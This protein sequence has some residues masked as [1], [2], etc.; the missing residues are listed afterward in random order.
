MR[1]GL[2]IAEIVIA[3]AILAVVSGVALVTLNPF[4]QVA[5]ARNTQ[6][7]MHLTALMSA[8]KQNI[9]ETGDSSFTCAVGPI[10][11][12]PTLMQSS[13][14]YD[15]AECIVPTFIGSMPFDPQYPGARYVSDN[16][17]ST[18]Y[19]ISRSA[20]TGQVTLDAPQAELGTTISLTR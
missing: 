9:A 13:G 1:K 7:T 14:G 19:R 3:L 15:I 18:G 20:T 11:T 16:D 4:G 17:Y 6:R 2:T 5:G 8:V 12:T 10:P